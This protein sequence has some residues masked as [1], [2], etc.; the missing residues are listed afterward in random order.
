MRKI[1]TITRMLGTVSAVVLMATNALGQTATA[2]SDT[3]ETVTVTAERRS[4]DQQK[5]PIT[6]STVSGVDLTQ[7]GINN[8]ESLQSSVPGLS[9]SVDTGNSKIFLRGVGTTAVA[10]DNS[11]GLYIDGMYVSAQASSFLNLSNIDHVE[12]LKGPQ[13]TLF[14]RNTTGGVI[15]IVTKDPSSTPAVDVSVGYGNYNTTSANF[16]GTTGIAPDLAVD[17][18]AYYNNQPDS[19]GKNVTTGQKN[20]Y[21]QRSL[22]L[23]NKWQ[24]TPSA[25]TKVTLSLDYA[26]DSQATGIDWSFLPGAKG[27]DG[28]TG[29]VGFYN[30]AGNFDGGYTD[31]NTDAILRVDQDFHWARAVSITGWRD[32]LQIQALDQDATPLPAVDA[33]PLPNHDKTFS[34]ELQLLSEED[35][36][37]QWI[38][39]FYY[40]NDRFESLPLHIGESGASIDVFVKEPTK[41][42]AEFGQATY[43]VLPATNLTVGLRYTSDTKSIN[44]ATFI[45][46]TNVLAAKQSANF[47]K[48]TYRASLDH[49]FTDDILGY[50]SYNRG[51]KSGQ[52]SLVNYN[53]APVNPEVLDAYEAGLKTQ[54]F[55]DHLRLNSSIF[56]YNYKNIQVQTVITGGT[57]L[58]N[59]AA[60]RIYGLD[61]DMDAIIT[62][63][64]TLKGSLEY[65]HGRYTNFPNDPSY[66]PIAAGGDTL[67]TINGKGLTTANSPDF[68]GYLSANYNIPTSGGAFDLNANLSYN[69]GFYWNPDNR[70]KQPAFTLVGGYLKWTPD[71]AKWDVRVWGNN[72]F[73]QKYY[74]FEDAFA[75]G[76]VYSPAAPA[77]FGVTVDAHL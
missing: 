34:E 51:F 58:E 54:M 18:S 71:S 26:S 3:L 52:Y 48:L 7:A 74:A 46:G 41:S 32:A 29:Y 25:D 63:A 65:L 36:K 57:Q 61:M 75:L 73:S 62:E 38:L 31:R 10:T 5:V 45:D 13:G 76:D 69:S 17:F 22:M 72:I 28:K 14:G 24:W 77:T 1:Y 4:E 67:I 64:F 23:R 33:R 47:S 35:S 6:I 30:T 43:E 11:V 39:G 9:I 12:V 37:L 60:A 27:I 70:L 66:V 2:P 68:T 50:V 42:V 40:L 15:Q 8:M 49:Q 53:L 55:D 44:G 19:W 16:Y 56:Y 20:I 59:A 21:K